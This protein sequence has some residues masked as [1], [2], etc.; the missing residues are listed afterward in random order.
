MWAERGREGG[1]GEERDSNFSGY[2]LLWHEVHVS[3]D[4]N[5]D[6]LTFCII[7][8]WYFYMCRVFI[9]FEY[10]WHVD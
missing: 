3:F 4:V 7:D 8:C 2:I 6:V 5:F 9:N 10:I 1:R